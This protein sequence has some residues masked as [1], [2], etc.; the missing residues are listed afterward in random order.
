MM[1]QVHKTDSYS[2]GVYDNESLI[3]A[4][5]ALSPNHASVADIMT[6]RQADLVRH[7]FQRMPAIYNAMM[8]DRT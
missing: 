7:I 3:D 5:D 1:I 2:R 4:I 6:T 8:E